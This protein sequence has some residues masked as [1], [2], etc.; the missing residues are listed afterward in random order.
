MLAF[1]GYDLLGWVVFGGAG[2]LACAWG[3]MKELWQPWALGVALMAFP[4]FIPSGALM[5]TIGCGLSGLVFFA[6][7]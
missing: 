4:Y 3:K 7:R 6:K 1:T 5:W 2:T